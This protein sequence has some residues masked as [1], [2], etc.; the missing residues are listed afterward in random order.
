MI[1]S[2]RTNVTGTWTGCRTQRQPSLKEEMSGTTHRMLSPH[3]RGWTEEKRLLIVPLKQLKREVE[4]TPAPVHGVG[5][6]ISKPHSESRCEVVSRQL[7]HGH[8]SSTIQLQ[9]G[10]G[11]LLPHKSLWCGENKSLYAYLQSFYHRDGCDGCLHRPH[12]L[13]EG[14]F[15][16]VG[17]NDGPG[18]PV[19]DQLLVSF[20]GTRCRLTQKKKQEEVLN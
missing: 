8:V 20:F 4:R 16:L 12:A 3:L 19:A 10:E 18:S 1:P 6:Y 15:R 7:Q 17:A 2:L 9:R 5:L 13:T 14:V 11:F